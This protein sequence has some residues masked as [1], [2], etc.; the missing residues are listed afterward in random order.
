MTDA[1]MV[2]VDSENPD[3]NRRAEIVLTDPFWSAWDIDHSLMRVR[4]YPNISKPFFRVSS[5]H[6]V[7]EYLE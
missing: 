4:A 6:D 7:V 2:Q 5:A 3:E 1:S